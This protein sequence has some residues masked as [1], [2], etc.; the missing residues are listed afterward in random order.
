MQKARLKHCGIIGRRSG[1]IRSCTTDG[2]IPRD[3]ITCAHY[4]VVRAISGE[5]ASSNLPYF[6]DKLQRE[7]R[8]L[9]II[10]CP[11]ARISLLRNENFNANAEITTAEQILLLSNLAND[12]LAFGS[13]S[14]KT[15]L[16]IGPLRT[17][18]VTLCEPLH[19]AAICRHYYRRFIDN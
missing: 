7:L 12:Y 9:V 18:S 1:T 4:G 8:V 19:S 14:A 17:Q 10:S 13:R 6:Q 5:M 15:I 2:L 11:R 3:R 16:I